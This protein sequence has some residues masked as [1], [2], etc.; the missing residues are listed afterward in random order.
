MYD[1]CGAYSKSYMQVSTRICLWRYNLQVFGIMIAHIQDQAH[2]HTQIPWHFDKPALS[3]SLPP[4]RS[5]STFQD[6]ATEFARGMQAHLS[7]RV[8]RLFVEGTEYL[9]HDSEGQADQ[10][11]L[12]DYPLE[13]LVVCLAEAQNKTCVTR[14]LHSFA[15][16]FD[17]LSCA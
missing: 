1:G 5:Q 6:A 17:N 16:P 13:R 14:M 11:R 12:R 7:M 3:D 10:P 8:V 2:S 15:K 4:R 9:V